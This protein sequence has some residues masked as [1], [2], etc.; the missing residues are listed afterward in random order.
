MCRAGDSCHFDAGLTMA[1]G[2]DDGFHQVTNPHKL[3]LLI[4]DDDRPL[5]VRELVT[6][7]SRHRV[8]KR[9]ATRAVDVGN[10]Q[11]GKVGA[12]RLRP[13]AE[14]LLAFALGPPISRGAI[15]LCRRGE[16]EMGP[17]ICGDKSVNQAFYK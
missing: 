4:I 12:M 15:A 13:L 8:I 3:N 1:Y 9:P 11:D 17:S 2:V 7:R 5:A 16:D 14:E 6:E 10:H